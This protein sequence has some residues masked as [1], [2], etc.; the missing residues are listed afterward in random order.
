[1][2]SA[3]ILFLN[4]VDS[5]NAPRGRGNKHVIKFSLVRLARLGAD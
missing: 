5:E 3:Y 2:M 1:M 4:F